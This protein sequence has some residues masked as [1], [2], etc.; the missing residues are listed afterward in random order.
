MRYREPL[1][2]GRMTARRKR[3]FADVVLESGEEIVA[4]CVNTGAMTGCFEPG[5]PAWVS[6]AANPNRKLAFTLEQTEFRGR[7][8]MVHTALANTIVVEAITAGL[9][10]SMRGHERL[11]R[12]AKVGDHRFD[13]LLE[14]EGGRHWVEVKNVTLASEGLAR[15]PD[16]VTERGARHMAALAALVAQGDRATLLFHVGATGVELVRIA[17]DIDPAYGR[18]LREAVAQGVRV[19]AWAS[20][21]DDLEVRVERQVPVEL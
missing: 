7:R 14:G 12:E 15:F 19:E 9:I 3:F 20:V 2:K 5:C 21:I 13:V 1:L 18:A 4:H 10:P 6:R 8:C 17:D 11:Q 16:A